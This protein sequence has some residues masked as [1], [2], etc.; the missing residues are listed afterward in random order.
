MRIQLK[1]GRDGPSTLACVRDDGTRTWSKL[2][3]FFPEHDLTHC[4]V[5]SVLGFREA[6]FGCIASGWDID[7]FSRP[8]SASRISTE[9]VIAEHI[10]GVF[11]LERGAGQV[12]S[13]VDFN[14]ALNSGLRDHGL[15]AFR[16]LSEDE[17]HR[18]RSVRGDLVSRWF[19]TLPGETFEV[20]FPV[21]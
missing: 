1:K 17:L 16:K 5:E 7:D 11:D 15:P 20:E 19:S 13:A 3:P 12:F 8:G 6:F 2:H 9:A 18:V 4:A 10:V 14:E 21:A